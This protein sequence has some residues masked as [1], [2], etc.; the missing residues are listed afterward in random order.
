[1]QA[2]LERARQDSNL[3]PLAP[4]ASGGLLRLSQRRLER[5]DVE[6][7]IRANHDERKAN[8]GQA[9]WLVR[10]MTPLGPW[11]EAIYDY[12]VGD[13]EETVRIV[14]AWRLES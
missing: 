12:P 14:S 3:R 6:E 2:L 5:V 4:E 13:D 8:D 11:I 10:A 1:M 9:D 7:V